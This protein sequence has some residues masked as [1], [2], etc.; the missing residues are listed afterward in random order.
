VLY[1]HHITSRDVDI[2]GKSDQAPPSYI[3]F[4]DPHLPAGTTLVGQY[5]SGVV[6]WG[7]SEW[8]IGTPYGKFGTFNLL[9]SDPNA[10]RAEFRF[11]APRIFAGIDVYNGGDRDSTVTFRSPGVREASFTIKPRELRR[12]RTGWLEAIP[13]V[14]LQLTN[15]QS[16]RFDNLAY[17][18]P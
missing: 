11:Y 14:S 18:H 15:G 16:L 10:S 1:I 17:V 9:L 5:P 4:D 13:A 2:H 6:D 8:K 7:S 3:T 12:V